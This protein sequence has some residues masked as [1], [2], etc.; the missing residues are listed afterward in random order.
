MLPRSA[1]LQYSAAR[2]RQHSTNRNTIPDDVH[3][4]APVAELLEGSKLQPGE[5]D[6]RGVRCRRGRVSNFFVGRRLDPRRG[7]TQK[8][9]KMSARR[10]TMQGRREWILGVGVIKRR[11]TAGHKIHNLVCKN[12]SS[13]T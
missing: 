1:A 10:T 12:T 3:T 6:R 2:H 5:P 7:E 9:K 13:V 4:E 8:N 11:R